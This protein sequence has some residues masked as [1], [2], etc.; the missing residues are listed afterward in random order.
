M[1]NST[2]S[3]ST[4]NSLA[5]QW[6]TPQELFTPAASS[7]LGTPAGARDPATLSSQFPSEAPYYELD[8]TSGLP[9]Q[10]EWGGEWGQLHNFESGAA[11]LQGNGTEVEISFQ[12]SAQRVP[13]EYLLPEDETP[14]AFTNNDSLTTMLES[15]T[16]LPTAV[17]TWKD[18]RERN[19][20]LEK[21]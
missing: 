11:I 15:E 20:G 17:A 16:E 4:Q 8:E 14:D 18:L 9:L 21:P 1:E 13:S 3:V 10:M 19:K 12:G 5:L 7:S 2:P 6:G